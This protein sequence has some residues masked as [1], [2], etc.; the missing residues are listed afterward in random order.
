MEAMSDR[1]LNCC[2]LVQA[3]AWQPREGA[4]NLM[5][6]PYLCMRLLSVGPLPRPHAHSLTHSLSPSPVAQALGLGELLRVMR[7]VQEVTADDARRWLVEREDGII[8]QSLVCFSAE[9]NTYWPWQS[10]PK[11]PTPGVWREFQR[12][13]G[14]G[15]F[16]ILASRYRKLMLVRGR[17]WG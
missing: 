4:H 13:W 9:T 17:A 15:V 5:V 16:Y 6:L 7:S 10:S 11:R 1:K 12:R 14:D 3:L 2:D 8:F